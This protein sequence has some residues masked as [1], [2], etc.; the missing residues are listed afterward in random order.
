M[1][2]MLSHD[3]IKVNTDKCPN[4]TNAY[5]TQGY[6]KKGDPEKFAA[7]PAID[8]WVDCSGYFINRKYPVR[9]PIANLNIRFK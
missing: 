2:G 9:K 7:H 8:D 1:N 4:L 5:E 6:D 3:R